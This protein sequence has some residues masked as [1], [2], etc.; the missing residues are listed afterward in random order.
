MA[1][2]NPGNLS[3]STAELVQFYV[4]VCLEGAP[5]KKRG[6]R[7]DHRILLG[8]RIST[9]VLQSK[10]AHHLLTISTSHSTITMS[11]SRAKIL[12]L[13]DSLTQLSWDGWGGQLAHAYQRRADVLNRGMAGYNTDW[14]LRY[15]QQHENDVFVPNVKLVIIFFGANDASDSHLNPR[16]YVAIPQYKDNLKS[17]I[18]QCRAH[19]GED[20]S[21]ILIS[22]P[23][24]Q[25]EQRIE[26]Q[27]QRYGENATGK[28]ER[29]L[30][31]S[32]QYA[33]A[34]EQ[35]ASDCNTLL[36][37]L[38]NDMQQDS[39]WDRF[40][41]DGLHFSKEGNDFVANAILK[42]IE[43]EL[44]EL[45]VTPCP[46][47]KQFANSASSCPALTQSGPFHDEIDYMNPSKAFSK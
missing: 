35:V 7:I 36:I 45:A 27:K 4:W 13:G 5:Q 11:A 2:K 20:V 24:V 15:I 44:P 23:P 6:T 34:A 38:W 16:H 41:Y 3:F 18:A 39:E 8:A 25:H 31:L 33:Q 17:L 42:T 21:I 1:S 43:T 29:N 12:L 47:T 40:F 10:N 30:K 32:G 9:H 28:L 14:F 26:Y 37:N 46:I 19:Y 22:P